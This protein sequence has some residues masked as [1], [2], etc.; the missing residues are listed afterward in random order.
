[1][2]CKNIGGPQ[3]LTI[4]K[5]E[6]FNATQII[7]WAEKD[8]R[9]GY[10]TYRCSF[11]PSEFFTAKDAYESVGSEKWT[12]LGGPRIAK[13]EMELGGSTA[14]KP[15]MELGGPAR[16]WIDMDAGLRD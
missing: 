13:P 15:E 4:T 9:W 12:E 2:P 6:S 16:D 11:E 14:A 7:A 10:Y 8:I 5:F 1:M 3:G